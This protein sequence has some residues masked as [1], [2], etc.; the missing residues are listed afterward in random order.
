MDSPVLSGGGIHPALLA[1]FYV[2]GTYMA[3]KFRLPTRSHYSSS[4]VLHGL[5]KTE[6]ISPHTYKTFKIR[7]SGDN[8]FHIAVCGWAGCSCSIRAATLFFH[9]HSRYY[10]VLFWIPHV[11]VPVN[12]S[13]DTGV[14][15]PICGIVLS[16]SPVI[17]R[18]GLCR[19]FASYWCSGISSSALYTIARP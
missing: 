4:I 3:D 11:K 10:S 5:E 16:I 18:S 13:C 9:Y 7:N 15:G 17:S 8:F 14:Y 1:V 6:I 19:S 2:F 12:S